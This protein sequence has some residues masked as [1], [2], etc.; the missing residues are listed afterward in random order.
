[1]TTI[2]KA[3]KHKKNKKKLFQNNFTSSVFHIFTLKQGQKWKPKPYSDSPWKGA[4]NH[5]YYKASAQGKSVWKILRM[6]STDTKKSAILSIFVFKIAQKCRIPGDGGTSHLIERH[7]LYNSDNTEYPAF[8]KH[9]KY[10]M[11]TT[12]YCFLD[13]LS[14]RKFIE[15]PPKLHD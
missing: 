15:L 7:L 14:L 6:N 10:L 5:V 12:K 4:S 11:N 1:M 13:V 3:V 8:Q 2:R 9:A